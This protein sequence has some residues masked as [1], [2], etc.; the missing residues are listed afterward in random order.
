LIIG[1]I[2]K[3]P[4]E[5]RYRKIPLTNQKFNEKV[6]RIRGGPGFLYS[7]GF[8]EENGFLIFPESQPI[9]SIEVAEA[10][11]DGIE[12]RHKEKKNDNNKDNN[13]KMKKNKKK[14]K[15]KK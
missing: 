10:F 8:K 4:V 13:Y 14:K 3:H 15:K 2:L 7:L 12:E 6:W 11:L 9:D 5:P 1:N